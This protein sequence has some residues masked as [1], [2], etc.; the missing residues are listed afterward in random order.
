MR[1][2]SVPTTVRAKPFVALNEIPTITKR[3]QKIKQQPIPVTICQKR[4]KSV[5]LDAKQRA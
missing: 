1:R 4:S 5:A 2:V 3:K